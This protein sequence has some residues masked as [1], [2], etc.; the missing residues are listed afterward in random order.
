[1]I[2][3]LLGLAVLLIT[4]VQLSPGQTK[5]PR[6]QC[7]PTRDAVSLKTREDELRAAAERML[8][9]FRE[10]DAKGFLAIV[11]P[12]YFQIGQGRSYTVSQLGRSFRHKEQI[13]CYLFDATCIPS[14]LPGDSPET[15]F[16]AAAKHSGARLLTVKIPADREIK[17]PGC[18]GTVTFAWTGPT[19]PATV[20]TFTFMYVNGQWVTVGFDFPPLQVSGTG[21]KPAN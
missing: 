9:M 8:R 13:Y 18:Q 3:P 20:S 1:M 16:S 4:S 15:S 11:H 7:E 19:D 2:R 12:S 5:P 14:A 17:R 21:E 10:A 6:P